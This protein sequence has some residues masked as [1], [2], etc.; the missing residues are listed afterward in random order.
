M[1]YIELMSLIRELQELDERFKIGLTLFIEGAQGFH[2]NLRLLLDVYLFQ[3]C[4]QQLCE[5]I[6]RHG[7]CWDFSL[8]DEASFIVIR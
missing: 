6:Q 7:L 3:E 1:D 5:L 8:R 4:N 2:G